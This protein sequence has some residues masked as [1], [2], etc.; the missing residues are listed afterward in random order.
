MEMIVLLIYEILIHE[1]V[2]LLLHD[3]FDQI[4]QQYYEIIMLYIDIQMHHDMILCEYTMVDMETIHYIGS[5]LLG[6]HQ[7]QI[8]FL[9]YRI[10]LSR[11]LGTI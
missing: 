7:M 10:S 6:M 4:R 9:R 2:A 8:I 5:I 1:I 11:T 3:G